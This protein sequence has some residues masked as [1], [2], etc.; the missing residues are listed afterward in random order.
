MVQKPGTEGLIKMRSL[1]Q[2]AQ[3]VAQLA[4]SVAIDAGYQPHADGAV[5]FVSD[6]IE[7]EGK[8]LR[9]LVNHMRPPAEG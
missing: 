4:V 2:V 8:I 7:L 9:W 3:E 1:D 6:L 5:V